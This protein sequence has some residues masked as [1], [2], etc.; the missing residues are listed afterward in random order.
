MQFNRTLTAAD[1]AGILASPQFLELLPPIERLNP[2][3]VSVMRGDGRIE[4]LSPGYDAETRSFTLGDI[5]FPVD[6]PLFEAKQLIS[7]LL[8]EFVFADSGRSLAV[9]VGAMLTVF[10]RGLLP[11]KSLRPCFVFVAN[12]EGAGKTMLVKI[13]VVPFLGYAPA[14]SAPS[15]EAEM[16]KVLLTVVME[17]RPVLFID[18]FKGHIQS[19]AL[20]AFCTASDY[21]GR[22][23]GV[24]KSFRGQ[25]DAIVIVTG[26]SCT[27][28]PDM[29]RRVLLGELF[30]EVERAEDRVFKRKLEVPALLAM[31]GRILGALWALVVAWD[32]AGRPKPSRSN[33]S[34]PDWADTIGGIVE[35]AG[36]GCP[37]ETPQIESAADQE[38]AD[39]RVLMSA[40]ANGAAVSFGELVEV[41]QKAG[42][43]ERV[44][45]VGVELETKGRATLAKLFK[46]FERRI[47]GDFRFLIEGR[48]HSRRFRVEHVRG[49][50]AEPVGDTEAAADEPRLPTTQSGIFGRRVPP[51]P[52]RE[53]VAT[54][55]ER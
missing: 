25:N 11:A 37:L 31:R 2:V 34:F 8:G 42:L 6:L 14:G 44:L 39:M 50:S 1:A 46:R 40:L 36:Y 51:K 30:L 24:S 7:E 15:N 10:A 38:G 9:V 13:I 4:L 54:E 21:E 19:A 17:A 3:R 52:Q 22:I 32:K 55:V 28:S 53:P 23:L 12:A 48:G 27:L 41:A 49:E 16:Q 33:S 35:N 47:V 43:F 26:N 5:E 29:R 20:E 18:N 45:P